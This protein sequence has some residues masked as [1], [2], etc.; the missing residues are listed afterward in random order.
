MFGS[1]S[2]GPQVDTVLCW[3]FIHLCI[4]EV[5]ENPTVPIPRRQNQHWE[6][7]VINFISIYT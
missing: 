2:Y 6:V 3:W 7:E 1:E 5:E 4:S